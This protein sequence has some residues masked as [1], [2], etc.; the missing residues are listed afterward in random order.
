MSKEKIDFTK[1]GKI[2][3]YK[4]LELVLKNLRN[5]IDD[6]T[7]EIYEIHN[8]VRQ[9]DL[10]VLVEYMQRKLQEAL[11]ELEY[12]NVDVEYKNIDDYE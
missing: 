12:I 10:K 1:D 7:S 11:D 5:Y 2:D 9:T 6:L 3:E 8:C 4:I